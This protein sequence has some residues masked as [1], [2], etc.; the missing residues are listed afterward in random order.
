MVLVCGS[1][2]SG[3]GSAYRPFEA[4]IHRWEA[5]LARGGH[6]RQTDGLGVWTVRFEGGEVRLGPGSWGVELAGTASDLMLILWQRIP[7]ERRQITGSQPVLSRYFT[8]VP[9]V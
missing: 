3:S 2:R 7:A 4:A 5:Q 9:P 1:R 8:L 6:F